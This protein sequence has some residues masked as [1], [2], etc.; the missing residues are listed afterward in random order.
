[1]SKKNQTPPPPLSEAQMEIMAAVWRGGPGGAT[2][3]EV[4]AVLSR[5]RK[6]AR[7]TVQTLM[8]R[9]EDKGWLGHRAEGTAFRY[10]A[11]RARETTLRGL[12]GRLVDAAFGGSAEG[13]VTALLDGRGLS[14]DEAGRIRRLIERAEANPESRPEGPHQR[15]G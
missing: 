15:K 13:L 14:G 5:R 7:N 8:T 9:L 11:R 4:W 12:V 2:V 3:A 10:Y 1:M 6:V